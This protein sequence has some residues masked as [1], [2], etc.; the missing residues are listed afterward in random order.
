MGRLGGKVA[1]VTGAGSGIGRA[2]AVLFAKEGAKIAVADF[3]ATAGRATVKMIKDSGGEATFF[4][5]D[6]S[7]AGQVEKTVKDVVEKYGR[8][9][10]LD[11]NAGVSG[12]FGQVTTISEQEWDHVL[13]VDLKSTFLFCKNVIPVMAKLGGGTIVNMSSLAAVVGVPQD[14][15]Y[16]AAKGGV[17]ALTRSMALAHY[18]DKIRINCICPGGVIT[19]MTEPW[20]P[21]D[22][23]EREAAFKSWNGPGKRGIDPEEIARGVLFLS[24]DDSS[25]IVGQALVMDLGHSIRS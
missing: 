4:E 10:I 13:G 15:S 16:S 7:K 2:V 18:D 8:I 24:C 22:K 17:L 9:D 20:L 14:P 5:V 6:V 23:G 11:N 3:A 21:K 19:A 25:A 12:P 1:L